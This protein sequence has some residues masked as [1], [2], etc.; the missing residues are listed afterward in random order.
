MA[1]KDMNSFFDNV[2]FSTKPLDYERIFSQ[3]GLSLKDENAGK[4][5]AWSGVV[6]SHANGKTTISNIY[7]NSPAVDAGLSVNDE[8]I[9]ING[10]RVDDKLEDHDAKYEVNDSVVITY[11]RDGK[12]YTAKLTYAKST[13]VDYKLTKADPEN[14]LQKAWLQK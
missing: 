4:T 12:I 10:W 3:Y 7:S 8:I 11:A 6:S 9:A 14:K 13:K 2:I 1:G 5:V